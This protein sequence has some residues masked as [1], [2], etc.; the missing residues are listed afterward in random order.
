[1]RFTNFTLA[2]K[3]RTR[4]AELKQMD[5]YF[6][7]RDGVDAAIAK[8]TPLTPARERTRICVKQAIL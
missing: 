4:V 7:I 1:M 6:A 2:E 3:L 8:V 5:P